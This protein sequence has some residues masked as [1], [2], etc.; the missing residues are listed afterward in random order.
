[1]TREEAGMLGRTAIGGIPPLIAALATGAAACPVCT[2]ELGQ[3][4]RAGIFGPDFG[5]NLFVAVLPFAVLAPIV[6]GIHVAVSRAGRS[7]AAGEAR[8][9]GGRWTR[10]STARR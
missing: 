3:Q 9:G 5:A 8:E 10:T 2:T 6:A 1:V 4:V 7:P